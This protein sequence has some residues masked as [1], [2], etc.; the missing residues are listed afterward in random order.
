VVRSHTATSWST[1]LLHTMLE[2]RIEGQ[3]VRG[4]KRQQMIDD[5]MGKE[6][7]VSIKRTAEDWTRWIARRQQH[8]DDACQQPASK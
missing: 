6:N 1:K 4:G 7:Y 5:I 8:K 2:G 3:R